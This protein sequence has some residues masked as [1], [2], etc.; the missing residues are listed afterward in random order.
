M[1]STEDDGCGG[2]LEFDE[3]WV[4]EAAEGDSGFM[5]PAHNVRAIEQ[6]LRQ[7]S[8]GRQSVQQ[9]LH[10]P[11]RAASRLVLAHIEVPWAHTRL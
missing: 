4:Q 10:R 8:A 7:W 2:E 1:I 9:L 11:V 5:Q 3:F 6:R